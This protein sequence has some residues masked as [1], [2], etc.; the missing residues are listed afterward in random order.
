MD[1]GGVT[2]ARYQF[3]EDSLWTGGPHSYAHPGAAEALPQIRQLLFEGKQS[4]AQDLATRRF[5]S[6]PIGQANYQPFGDVTLK[7]NTTTPPSNYRRSLSLE[8][9]T[10]TARFDSGGVRYTRRAFASFP[11]QVI[12][13]EVETDKPGTL[14]FTSAISSPQP[15]WET[16]DPDGATLLLT[17]RVRDDNLRDADVSGQTRFAAHLRIGSTDGQIASTDKRLTV[18]GA[19]R[20]TLLLSAATSFVNF[21]NVSADPVARS[22][23]HLEAASGKSFD[24]LHQA[25]TADHQR[26]FDRVGLDLTGDYD[27]S[28]PTDDRV[29]ASH[30]NPDPQLA[31]L[32]FHY[33]RYLMIAS[34]RPG[35]QPA[36]LQGLW[37][38]SLTPA[39]GSK[40]TV[41]IN[42]EMNY[43]LTE[44]CNLPECE[45]PLFAALADLAETGADIARQQYAAPGWVL[46][47]NFD[48]WRGAAPINASNHGIWP[49]GGAWLCSQMW[50][51]FLYSGDVGFLRERAYPLMKG[52]AG[53]FAAYLVEDP[54]QD[55]N[56]LISGPSNSPEQGGLVMG[57]TMDHQIVR[58]LFANTIE[59]S[60]LLG[61]DS[62]FRDR[63]RE[64]RAR[65]APNQIGKHGQ[66]QEWLEDV[67]DPSNQHRHV[68]HLWGLY[69][70]SEISLD[71][72]ELFAAA[73][74]SLEFRGDEG[75]GWSRAWKINFWARLHDGDRA[76]RVLDGL[77]TLTDSPKTGYRGG[78][79]YTNLFDAHPPFQ[80]DGNFGA[81][82]GVCEMLVQ[83]HRRTPDG[84]RMIEL[85]PALPVA[86]PSGSVTGLRTRDGFEVDVAWRVGR[87]THARV[88]SHL[89]RRALLCRDDRQSPIDLAAGDSVELDG[90]LAV[91]ASNDPE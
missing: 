88:C 60:E 23:D 10:T 9:A 55:S 70:G 41:N 37:N 89:G 3:N 33:G 1:F 38:D 86:W 42:T 35:G 7:F 68:S 65:I 11:D 43:W 58:E 54:R 36:N 84:V 17:G 77:L 32:L 87:M 64:L 56:L 39:W 21:R 6:Q 24:H 16:T 49:M 73:R 50:E 52:A 91:L 76:L 51:H 69:P 53:F 80:I 57:P 45:E 19:S 63:L 34:S 46:H 82:A 59:A 47:H 5:M 25:H 90:Q 78:G 26:L 48:L 72:P 4:D 15:K 61:V 66:L 22:L 14:E 2:E 40:Y 20:A 28:L 62:G 27:A 29:L 79:V 85:L 74:Q 8:S 44:P 67:D 12:V 83:S 30:K 13:I 71:T 31:A 75:T 18:T 81:T